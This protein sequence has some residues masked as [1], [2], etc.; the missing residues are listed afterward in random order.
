MKVGDVVKV[1]EIHWKDPGL[2]GI[3]IHDLN[4]TGRA[5]KVLLSTGEVRP[6]MASNLEMISESR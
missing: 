4:D 1:K 3:I 5:F 2:I 6:K